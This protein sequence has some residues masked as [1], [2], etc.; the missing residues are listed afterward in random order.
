MTWLERFIIGPIL[1]LAR[2]RNRFSDFALS[3]EI[4][5]IRRL[6]RFIAMLFSALAA[7]D[8]TTLAIV[9]AQG[10]GNRLSVSSA[11]LTLWPLTK[12]MMGLSLLWE[13]PSDFATALTGGI[14][15]LTRLVRS[16]FEI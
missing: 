5:V 16:D 3:A 10:E 15:Y 4:L 11:D 6:S 7:A 9:L 1:P 13:V 8:A 12:S 14:Y 2:G